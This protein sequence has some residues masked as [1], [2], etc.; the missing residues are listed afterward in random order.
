VR[1]VMRR[2]RVRKR[3]QADGVR[4]MPAEAHELHGRL[5]RRRVRVHL[6]PR[7]RRKLGRRRV[8]SR[9]RR[10]RWLACNRR[11]PGDWRHAGNGRVIRSGRNGQRRITGHRGITGYRWSTGGM[12]PV[13]LW[14]MR[15]RR[16]V[17][18]LRRQRRLRLFVVRS[19]LLQLSR[20][21]TSN[22][23]PCASGSSV[24]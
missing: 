3:V 20:P 12:R 16:A 4:F 23:I 8:R 21:H 11:R 7:L 19:R 22:R 18:V 14:G 10:I 1:R 5:R 2:S 24:E 9:G 6:Q 17:R 15:H 13:A